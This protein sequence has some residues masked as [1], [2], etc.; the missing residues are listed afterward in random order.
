MSYTRDILYHAFTFTFIRA[1]LHLPVFPWQQLAYWYWYQCFQ[2]WLVITLSW[3][4]L[5]CSVKTTGLAFSDEM[6]S[7]YLFFI[8]NLISLRLLRRWWSMFY[9][10][11]VFIKHG[12]FKSKV[13]FHPPHKKKKSMLWSL[14]IFSFDIKT[15]EENRWHISSHDITAGTFSLHL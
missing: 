10:D 1:F 9:K 13:T 7:N 5:G 4:I 11:S 15:K 3:C 8:F 14:D 6:R 12:S 2:H